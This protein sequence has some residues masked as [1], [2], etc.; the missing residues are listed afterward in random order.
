MAV[1]DEMRSGFKRSTMLMKIVWINVGLFVLLRVTAIV[2][3]FS[4][5]RGLIDLVLR[6]VEMPSSP[7]MLAGRPWTPITYMFAQYDLLHIL[8][9]MLWLYW[10]GTLFRMRCTARQMLA[11]YIYGGLGGAILFF[12]AYNL[13]PVFYGS[14]GW[15]IGSSASVMAIVTA[16]ALLMPD[17]RMNL[18]LIGSVSLK[19]I[20]IAT[21]VLVLV[22]I[23]GE[24]A[25]GE[26]AHVGGI[27]T[28]ALFATRLRK[29][30]DITSPLNSFL[31]RCANIGSRIYRRQRNTP[32]AA[33]PRRSPSASSTSSTGFGPAE[34][35]E[36]DILLEK[37]KK[38]GYSGLTPEERRRLFELSR[39]IK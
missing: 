25:G 39:N 31:D 8:F 11:L 14:S 26:I 23:S 38:S 19:W 20:A 10:F 33:A 16:T 1:I 29:G 4:A 32:P 17:F 37:I 9:N 22:G 13:M 21:I 36:L 27:L 28:G 30:H 6:Y 35:A 15:L 3:M 5:S 34:R 12:A 2:G 7:A 24:N 18:L